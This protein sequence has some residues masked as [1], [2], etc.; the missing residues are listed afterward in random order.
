MRST[1]LRALCKIMPSSTDILRFFALRN[2]YF[3][4]ETVQG[5]AERVA[6]MTLVRDHQYAAFRIRRQTALGRGRDDRLTK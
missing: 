6:N 5:F 4:A 3:D 2:G 1:W